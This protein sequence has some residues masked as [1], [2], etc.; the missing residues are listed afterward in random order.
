MSRSRILCILIFILF[1]LSIPPIGETAHIGSPLSLDRLTRDS[2]LVV[3]ATALESAR[4]TDPS[5]PTYSGNFP[6]MGTRFRVISVFKG[7]GTLKEF[8]FHH[9]G[10]GQSSSGFASTE[11]Q[12]YTFEA[13]QTYILFTKKTADPLVFRTFEYYWNLLDDHGVVR[14]AT[15]VPFPKGTTPQSAIWRELT[16]M[17]QGA[18][19][20]V[21]YGIQHLDIYSNASWGVFGHEDFPR[22]EVLQII[23]PLLLRSDEAVVRAAVDAIGSASPYWSDGS[24]ERM[25][26]TVSSAT[27]LPVME[28]QPGFKNPAACCREQLIAL[29]N[30]TSGAAKY[31]RA[32]AIRSL[33]RTRLNDQDTVLLDPLRKWSRDPDSR[34]RA[35]ATFLWIDFPSAESVEMMRSLSSDTSPEVK[36]AVAYSIGISQSA[37]LVDV[38]ERLLSEGDGSTHKAAARSLTC[39]DIQVVGPILKKHVADRGYG[40][41]FLNVLAA[42]DPESYRD[43]LADLI[44]PNNAGLSGSI[45]DGEIPT[46]TAWNTLL[47]YIQKSNADDVRSGKL[48][49][50]LDA[51]ETPP[52]TGSSP[53]QTL[54]RF[55]KEKGLTARMESFREKVLRQFPSYS[56]YLR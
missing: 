5:F 25:L 33:G 48:D 20:D 6:I 21:V 45:L 53:Y 19:S 16:E 3:K 38:L 8:T 24:A 4:I 14:A 44:K 49:K 39:M 2:D 50:Y 22:K 36:T 56:D 9:F 43:Q 1:S 30:S 27:K 26:S 37:A 10:V 11:P 28:F 15:V 55:Y 34:V 32:A 31:Y 46:Y 17:L 54:F 13:G 23:S 12:M 47:A 18:N 35:A 41:A 7:D 52:N 29:A 42:A 40:L 51:L